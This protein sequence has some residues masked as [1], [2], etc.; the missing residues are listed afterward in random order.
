[1]AAE[2]FHDP[3]RV[4]ENAAQTARK[5]WRYET[6]PEHL[7]SDANNCTQLPMERWSNTSSLIPGLVLFDSLELSLTSR[8]S[9]SVVSS[10]TVDALR[11]KDDC[12]TGSHRTDVCDNSTTCTVVTTVQYFSIQPLPGYFRAARTTGACSHTC[13]PLHI[14]PVQGLAGLISLKNVSVL[15]FPYRLCQRIHVEAPARPSFCS[16]FVCVFRVR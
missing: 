1:M 5:S 11:C 6:H 2:T 4:P 7:G 13:T 3:A 10:K 8:V 15:L 14:R 12:Y 9:S 16:C